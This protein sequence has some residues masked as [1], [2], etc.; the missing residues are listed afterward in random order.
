MFVILLDLLPLLLVS[1]RYCLDTA[2]YGNLQDLEEQDFE[3]QQAGEQGRCS[4]TML[5]LCS[6]S[7][8][9]THLPICINLT[10]YTLIPLGLAFMS[11]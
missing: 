10:T 4:L 3:Q 11:G 9:F 6:F 7:L 1:S 8:Q 5:I 2:I